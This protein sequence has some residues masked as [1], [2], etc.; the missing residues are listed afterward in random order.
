[1]ARDL[2]V[3][4]ATPSGRP[5]VAPSTA[6]QGT[7]RC[8]AEL[9]ECDDQCVDAEYD[10]QHCG[11]CGNACTGTLRCSS[12]TCNHGEWAFV[13][14][15]L[16]PGLESV[17]GEVTIDSNWQALL[18]GHTSGGQPAQ[19][20]GWLGDV[21]TMLDVALDGRYAGYIL[22]G[23]DVVMLNQ[24]ALPIHSLWVRRTPGHAP[25]AL[26]GNWAVMGFPEPQSEVLRADFLV[27]GGTGS[28]SIV[29]A[30]SSLEGTFDVTDLGEIHLDLETENWVGQV[31]ESQDLIL[32]RITD[33]LVPT[34]GHRPGHVVMVRQSSLDLESLAGDWYINL[35]L[36][37]GQMA[38]GHVAISDDAIVT[39]IDVSLTDTPSTTSACPSGTIQVG[40]EGA[41]ELPLAYGPECATTWTLEGWGGAIDA[42][43]KPHL[44][45]LR[46]KDLDG[47]TL[48]IWIR[49]R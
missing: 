39:G 22:A 38:S 1:M 31:S 9:V 41:L 40:Q 17:H 44:L 23:L 24:A 25:D 47:P 3:H 35:L 36:P 27:A 12:A 4:L 11:L 2:V 29:G 21:T 48:G 5:D 28:V 34:S 42:S 19:L 37:N 14:T 43:G 46:E 18:A 33:A 49:V 15:E 10:D 45:V 20:A 7:C 13:R 8:A 6:L 32:L 30:S 16:A 26:V